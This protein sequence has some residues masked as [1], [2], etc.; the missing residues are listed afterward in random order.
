MLDLFRTG[1]GGNDFSIDGG[2]TVINT[3]NTNAAGDLGDWA[4]LTP[5]AYNAFAGAGMTLPVSAGDLT[6]LDV[7]G[8]DPAP[9]PL[10]SAAGLLASGLVVLAGFAR[11]RHQGL[12]AGEAPIR[13]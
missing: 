1:T 7:I 10:P 4:G 8:Y 6:A 3:F 11:R 12:R 2:S 9:V 5:D 13:A